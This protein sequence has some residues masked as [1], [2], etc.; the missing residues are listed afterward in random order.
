[1]KEP[2]AKRNVVLQQFNVSLLSRFA[3]LARFAERWT[4]IQLN[5]QRNFFIIGYTVMIDETD[6]NQEETSKLDNERCATKTTDEE[7]VQ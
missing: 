6:D 3:I 4:A 7:V 5:D 2:A 1:M